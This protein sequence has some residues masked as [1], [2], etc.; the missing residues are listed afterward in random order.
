MLLRR[1]VLLARLLRLDR[2]EDRA[3]VAARL[4]GVAGRRRLRLGD[5]A[6]IDDGSGRCG[7]CDRRRRR[8]RRRGGDLRRDGLGRRRR[9]GD[10]GGEAAT[11]GELLRVVGLVEARDLDDVAG[12]RRVDELVAAERHADVVHVA[13]RVAEEHEVAGQQLGA[14]DRRAVR[15]LDLGVGDAR[16]LDAGLRVGPLHEA[17]AVEAGLRRRAA[18]PVRRAEV[19]LRLLDR[20]E[21]LRR[22]ATW[23]ARAAAPRRRARRHPG[24]SGPAAFGDGRLGGLA[25]QVVGLVEAQ[26]VAAAELLGGPFDVGDPFAVLVGV[27]DRLAVGD[28]L[29]LDGLGLVEEPLDLELGLVGVAGVRRRCSRCRRASGRSRRCRGRRRGRSSAPTRPAR[30]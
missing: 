17:G 30:P 27:V 29:L 12:V 10:R 28:A 6:R 3:A 14:A 26:L 23:R 4:G 2:L 1:V 18:V 7:W 11:A 20:R 25:E 9:P 16:D 21:R 19:L 15:R 24:T 22:G 8:G 13:R 5:R